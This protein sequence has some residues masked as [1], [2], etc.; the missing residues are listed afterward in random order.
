MV[1]GRGSEG[2][3][4][5]PGKGEDLKTGSQQ[6]QD[7]SGRDSRRG[8]PGG[9]GRSLRGAGDAG[10]RGGISACDVETALRT[11]CVQGVGGEEAERQDGSPKLPAPVP[12]L[13]LCWA[14]G[15]RRGYTVR[16]RR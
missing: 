10:R 11:A 5:S 15:S 3:Q 4:R 1:G 16:A 8:G 9:C 14:W 7:Q 2:A 12:R 13:L 6:G